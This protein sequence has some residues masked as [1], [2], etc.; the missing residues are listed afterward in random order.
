M[1][2]RV[3]LGDPHN[4]VATLETRNHAYEVADS[5]VVG[6]RVVVQTTGFKSWAVRY[7]FKGRTRKFTLGPLSPEQF[8]ASRDRNVFRRY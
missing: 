8:G 2:K 7:V 4:Y 1:G 3:D 5:R 6:L